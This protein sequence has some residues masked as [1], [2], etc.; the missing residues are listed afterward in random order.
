MK[1]VKKKRNFQDGTRNKYIQLPGWTLNLMR[2]EDITDLPSRA[3]LELCA[4]VSAKGFS[5]LGLSLKGH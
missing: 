3:A 5:V 4:A 1:S 2:G